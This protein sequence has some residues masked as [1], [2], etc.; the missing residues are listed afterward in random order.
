MPR[1]ASV[2]R[3]GQARVPS[4]RQVSQPD[5]VWWSG[6]YFELPRSFYEL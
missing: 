6:L 3:D 2:A 5:T 4:R 1:L